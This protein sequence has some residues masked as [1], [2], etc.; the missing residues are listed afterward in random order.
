MDSFEGG[1]NEDSWARWEGRSNKSTGL[2]PPGAQEIKR[3]SGGRLQSYPP[4]R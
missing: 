4:A 1:V 2:H 3:G